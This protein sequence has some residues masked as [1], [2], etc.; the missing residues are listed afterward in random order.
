M[1][2]PETVNLPFN[3]TLLAGGF[4]PAAPGIPDDGAPGIWLVIRGNALVVEERGGQP[5]L[6]QG[7]PPDWL[8]ADREPIRFGTW[9]GIPLRAV[10]I[11]AKE[12]LAAPLAL[13]PFNANSDR[14]DDVSLTLGGMANQI[15]HWSGSSRCCSRCGGHLEPLPGTWGRRCPSC[16]TEHYPH[17]HPCA[18]VLVRRGDE[19]LLARKPEWPAGR[20]GL[21]AGFLDFG[22]S[23]EECARREVREETGVEVANIRYVGSQCWPFPSQLM[24]GFVADYAGGELCCDQNE[25]ED[26]RWF[27]AGD[28]PA[29]LPGRRSI[30]RWII[31]RF[32]LGEE[33]P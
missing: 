25:I 14:L 30:A 23:L 24:A 13:E 28:M 5:F 27:C 12:A 11:S 19:F 20:Y 22:E 9:Q 31:D 3:A 33:A 2:Y 15:L 17:I 10:R 26:A 8:P 32:A 21:V 1:R 7:G 16:R 18:I 29:S 6:P 4:V